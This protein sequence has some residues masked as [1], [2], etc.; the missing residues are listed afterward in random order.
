LVFRP[1][2]AIETAEAWQCALMQKARPSILCLS[3]QDLPSIRSIPTD[4]N[5]VSRGAYVVTETTTTMELRD[6]TLLATGSEVSIAIEAAH[7][8][9]AHGIRAA[10]VSM[11][12]WELFEEQPAAYQKEVLGSAPRIAIEAASRFG[13]DRWIGRDGHFIGMNGFGASGPASTLFQHFG[14]TADEVVS[15]VN[16]CMR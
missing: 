13:W 14:I 8:L 3:R 7:R 9:N 12:C 1:A 4:G 5:L 6:I 15:T 16:A 11:P 10:V 2:D